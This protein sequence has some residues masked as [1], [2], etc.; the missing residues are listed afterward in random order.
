MLQ[1]RDSHACLS[2][3]PSAEAAPLYSLP[4]EAPGEH[5]PEACIS[6]GYFSRCFRMIRRL[7]R[8]SGGGVFLCEH[9]LGGNSLGQY[10][11]KII[12]IGDSD[13]WLRDRLTEVETMSRL[14][15]ENVVHFRHAWVELAKTSKF[16]EFSVPCLFLLMEAATL[17]SLDAWIERRFE[18]AE[19]C[20]VVSRG[21]PPRG[22]GS[23]LSEIRSIALQVALGVQHLHSLG[24]AHRDIKPANVLLTGGRPS[25]VSDSEFTVLLADLGAACQAHRR[26]GGTGTRLFMAPEV[27]VGGEK[28]DFRAADVWSFGVLLYCVAYGKP[29][30]GE[31]DED[32][33]GRPPPEFSRRDLRFDS[34]LADVNRVIFACLAA[35][36]CGR[37]SIDRVVGM[38]KRIGR[39]RRWGVAVAVLLAVLLLCLDRAAA[40]KG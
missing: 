7:G 11:L 12:P 35:E 8:G 26:N 10:A 38:C 13:A 21:A 19:G 2:L 5:L 3:L 25:L 9:R 28:I 32:A 14:R 18:R 27:A 17:G 31:R 29:P 15:H 40:A 1:R 4:G 33:A 36:P 16:S 37:P 20:L 30:T 24:I 6:Q 22:A 23:A 34:S 39:R